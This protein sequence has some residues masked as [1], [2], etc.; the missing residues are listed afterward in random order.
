MS[1]SV[2]EFFKWSDND[3]KKSV[4]FNEYISNK[5]LEL[6]S[7]VVICYCEVCGEKFAIPRGI[8]RPKKYCCEECRKNARA[9][10]SRNK[11]HKY[12]HRHKHE[13]DDK[14]RWGLGSG[15]LGQHRHKDFSKEEK[16]IKK[17]LIRLRLK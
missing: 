9:Q 7:S 14:R 15:T 10:Q 13:L 8:G 12:Y 11:S 6:Q 17:E 16:T 3:F 1:S 5:R 2:D 4:N